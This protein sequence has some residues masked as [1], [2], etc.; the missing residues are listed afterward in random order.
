M[1]KLGAYIGAAVGTAIAA[2]PQ[3][4]NACAMCGLSPGDHAIH[5]YNTSVLFMLSAPYVTFAVFG[6]IMF[7][8]WRRSRRDS[9]AEASKR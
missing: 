2:A 5:A 1:K 6:S 3:I 4:A 9:Q 8:A 7:F